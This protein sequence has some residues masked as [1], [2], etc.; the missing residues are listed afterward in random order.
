M[1]MK[2]P[3]STAVPT[4]ATPTPSFSPKMTQPEKKMLEMEIDPNKLLKK[5]G[6]L[7]TSQ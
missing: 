2:A 6:I 5:K 1:A 3:R 4:E 7:G